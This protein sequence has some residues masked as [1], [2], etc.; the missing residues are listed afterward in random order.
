MHML[1]TGSRKYIL[2]IANIPLYC[3]YGGPIGHKCRDP[4][5]A[6]LRVASQYGFKFFDWFSNVSS[7]VSS[8]IL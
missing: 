1:I 7:S 2:V 5:C 8:N 6:G 3:R 4:R